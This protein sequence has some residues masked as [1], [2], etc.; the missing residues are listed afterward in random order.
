MEQDPDSP[1]DGSRGMDPVEHGPK[2]LTKEVWEHDDDLEAKVAETRVAVR[3]QALEPGCLAARAAA[4][5]T[6]G[7]PA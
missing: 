2:V 7:Y 5:H 4:P 6:C 3:G 1:K